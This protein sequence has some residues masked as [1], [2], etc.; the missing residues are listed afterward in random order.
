MGSAQLKS[1]PMDVP[2]G[3]SDHEP[4]LRSPGPALPGLLP[5][6]PFFSDGGSPLSWLIK[7]E[8][9]RRGKKRA[10]RAW[11]QRRRVKVAIA[12]IGLLGCFFLVD[13]LMLLRLEDQEIQ[14]I[15][16]E[17]IGVIGNSSLSSSVG[18]PS[19]IRVCCAR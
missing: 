13:W 11:Y 10:G 4:L 12:V 8:S 2:G 1:N 19:Q 18:V 7:S 6:W 16:F 3:P 9:F 5:H 15:S 17:D 14:H